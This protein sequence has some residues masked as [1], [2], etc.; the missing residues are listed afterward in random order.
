MTGVA[1]LW[2]PEHATIGAA[3]SPAAPT[4]N[5]SHCFTWYATEHVLYTWRRGK[6]E[7]VVGVYVDDLIAIGMLAED[8]DSFKCKMAVHFRM[9]DLGVLSY[10]LGIEVRLGKEALMLGQSAYALK[11]LEWSG[12]AECKPCMTPME[13]R[14]KL[15]KAST[16]SKL[17]VTLYRSI[18]GGL[19][20]LVHTRPDI[21]FA[22]GYVSHFMEDPREHH[23]VTVKRLLRYGKGTDGQGIVFPKTGGS[24]L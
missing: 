10:Y 7:V 2:A 17:D 6:E 12:M 3:P 20:Y 23:W 15:M 21:A 24:R 16:A 9:S 11:R 18:V 19:R 8:I 5:L 22:M 1:G 4:K 13:E 14:L